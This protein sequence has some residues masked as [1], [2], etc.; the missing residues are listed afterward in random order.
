MY[1]L[2]ARERYYFS[3]VCTFKMRYLDFEVIVGV[4]KEA[5]R[6][7]VSIDNRC[8]SSIQFM[9]SSIIITW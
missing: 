2:Y 8:A 5:L 3:L 6:F 1:I 9:F 4:Q 7:R